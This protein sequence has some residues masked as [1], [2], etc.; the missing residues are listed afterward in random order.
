[1]ERDDFNQLHQRIPKGTKT[2]YKFMKFH[3]G[4]LPDLLT[5]GRLYF[6]MARQLNDP[7]EN[8]LH[9]YFR[10]DDGTASY[11]QIWCTASSSCGG[12][13]VLDDLDAVVEFHSLD[14]FRELPKAA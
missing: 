6:P 14:H 13:A 9:S 3:K 2:I 10:W 12:S 5:N 1:M 11:S 7:W 4:H 8:R